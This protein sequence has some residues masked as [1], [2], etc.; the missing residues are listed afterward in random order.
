M[1][2]RIYVFHA[3]GWEGIPFLTP[4]TRLT[5]AYGYQPERVEDMELERIFRQNNAVD[6]TEWNC[7]YGLGPS[8]WVMW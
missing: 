8:R 5:L 1:N 6:G 3:T 2:A 4:P 7:Q